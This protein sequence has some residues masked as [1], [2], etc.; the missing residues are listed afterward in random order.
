MPTRGVVVIDASTSVSQDAE[1]E[2]EGK[3]DFLSPAAP[4]S[5]LISI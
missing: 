3:G 4:S 1:K 5:W 2:L